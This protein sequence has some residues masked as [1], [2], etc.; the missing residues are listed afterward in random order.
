M[1]STIFVMLIERIF[2]SYNGFEST[3]G[4]GVFWTVP[5]QYVWGQYALRD[6]GKLSEEIIENLPVFFCYFFTFCHLIATII[7]F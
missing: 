2:Q 6:K 3:T 1:Y 5:V 4:F 7:T